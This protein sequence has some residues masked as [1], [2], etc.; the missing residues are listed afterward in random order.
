[1]YALSESH[2]LKHPDFI[3]I[4]VTVKGTVKTFTDWFP[5]HDLPSEMGGLEVAADS[6]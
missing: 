2:T 6:H 5:M 3:P 4:Q 1:M